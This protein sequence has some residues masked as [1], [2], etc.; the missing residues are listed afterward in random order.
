M[1]IHL[2]AEHLLH[3]RAL[4]VQA[5]LSTAS[6]SSTRATL[7]AD[8]RQLTLSHADA[9]AS[10]ELPAR[11]AE[12]GDGALTMP[13]APR[14]ELSFRIRLADDADPIAGGKGSSEQGNIVPW[15]ANELDLDTEIC[16]AAC[17]TVFV[18]R[19][20]IRVWKDLPSE[21]WAEMMEFW[22]CHKPEVAHDHNHGDDRGISA[23]S[24]LAVESG[25]GLV[26]IV[27]FLLAKEDCTKIQVGSDIPVLLFMF[28][29][30]HNNPSHPVPS[31]M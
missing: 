27:D 7:T 5:S 17:S 9:T 6:N 24:R 28:S 26:D 21:G 14:K 20:M 23:T 1:T 3:I 29:F 4:S 13:A 15:S 10:I 31:Q 2:Y 8:G 11:A 12:H 18:G 30:R 25:V 22:H 19:G 16:C